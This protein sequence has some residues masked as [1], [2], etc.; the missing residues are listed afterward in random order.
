MKVRTLLVILVVIVISGCA[1]TN[2]KSRIAADILPS[3]VS[4]AER[5]NSVAPNFVDNWDIVSGIIQGDINYNREVSGEVQEIVD[6]LD[7]IHL[8]AKEGTWSAKDKGSMISLV[9]DLEIKAG[10]YLNNKYGITDLVQEL[11]L[12][13]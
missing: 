9:V 6:R 3:Y 13:W 7:A 10:Q 2:I 4:T 1:Y 11:I 5:V 12:S 8:K